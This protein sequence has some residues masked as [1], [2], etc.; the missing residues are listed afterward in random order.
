MA[1]VCDSYFFICTTKLMQQVRPGSCCYEIPQYSHLCLSDP[2]CFC[3][4]S[5]HHGG[6]LSVS[7][8]REPAARISAGGDSE[9]CS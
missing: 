7:L 9:L 1:V 3:P 8:Y 4:E 2:P 5:P 6:V